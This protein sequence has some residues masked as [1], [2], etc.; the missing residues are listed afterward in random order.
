ML[1]RDAHGTRRRIRP[2]RNLISPIQ[3]KNLLTLLV[4]LVLLSGCRGPAV[5]KASFRD[6]SEAYAGLSNEQMLL[7]LARRAN[8]HPAYFLQMGQI[9]STFVFNRSASANMAWASQVP[10]I[11]KDVWNAGAGLSMS[12]TEQPTFSMTPLGGESFAAAIFNPL[13]PA[14]FYNLYEQG[15]PV[16][17]LL[18]SMVQKVEFTWPD[19]S[20]HGLVNVIDRERPENYIMFLRLAGLA[21]ELQKQQLLIVTNVPGGR[22]SAFALKPGTDEVM[23]KMVQEHP[24]FNFDPDMNKRP[25]NGAVSFKLSTFEGVLVALATEQRLFDELSRTR[26]DFRNSIP[27][28]ERQ[29]ILRIDWEG[30]SGERTPP[31]VEVKYRSKNYLIADLLAKDGGKPGGELQSWNRDVFVLLTHVFTQISLDPN[32]LPVQQ[33]IQIR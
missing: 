19:G 5:M 9:N 10:G 32:K 11:P 12:A 22:G 33:L 31:V 15:V 24:Y 20:T 1:L 4:G 14:I 30:I 26:P 3:F 2:M 29:P 8:G 23:Q 16:D 13:T 7:N 28:S 25:G 18:R 17:Q 21:R 6:Y 27:P